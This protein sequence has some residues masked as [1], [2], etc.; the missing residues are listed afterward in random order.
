MSAIVSHFTVT[1]SVYVNRIDDWLYNHASREC[2]DTWRNGRRN[3]DCDTIALFSH[4][5][6]KPALFGTLEYFSRSVQDLAKEARE[7]ST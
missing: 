1:N 6:F 5:G 2:L 3:C 4:N 7:I